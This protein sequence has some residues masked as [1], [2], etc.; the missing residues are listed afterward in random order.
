MPAMKIDA[1]K[2]DVKVPQVKAQAPGLQVGMPA[3]K[4]EAPKLDV[5]N[6]S[7]VIK[8]HAAK[9]LG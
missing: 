2:L 3:M 9:V 4:V 1:P 6:P 8:L 5:K 7:V